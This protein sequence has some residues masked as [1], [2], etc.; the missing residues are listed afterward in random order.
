MRSDRSHR[1]RRGT[2]GRRS[3]RGPR[4]GRDAHPGRRAMRVLLIGANG[5]IGRFV[6][7]RLL[8]DPAV[9]LTALG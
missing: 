3:P 9:Q 5:Y 1:G 2:R 6:A 8:A 4:R 7:D